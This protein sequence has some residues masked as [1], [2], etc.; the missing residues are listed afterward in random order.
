MVA[1]VLHLIYWSVVVEKAMVR[2]QFPSDKFS[3][4]I[5]L[6]AKRFSVRE[7]A[8]TLLSVLGLTFTPPKITIVKDIFPT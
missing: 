8:L 3:R 6:S 4:V 2:I 1:P 5:R 7:V